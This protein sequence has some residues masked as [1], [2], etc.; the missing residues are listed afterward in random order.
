[1]TLF[2]LRFSQGICP[3]VPPLFLHLIQSFILKYC[4]AHD[5]LK[6]CCQSTRA[7]ALEPRLC[8]PAP[9]LRTLEAAHPPQSACFWCH[10]LLTLPGLR[11]SLLLDVLSPC[12]S[13]Q[14]PPPS[15]HLCYCFC[16]YIWTVLEKSH[17]VRQCSKITSFY[18]LSA[19]F[20]NPPQALLGFTVS[21]KLL[22]PQ[23]QALSLSKSTAHNLRGMKLGLKCQHLQTPDP[24]NPPI[25]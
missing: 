20:A 5:H 19:P 24:T 3:V 17:T 12:S 2:E 4:Q 11:Q 1:M 6:A 10:P 21:L 18:V 9:V 7:S 15:P 23:P 22:T 25:H 14:S 8:R 13:L 16:P